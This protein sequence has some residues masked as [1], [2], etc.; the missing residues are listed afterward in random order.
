L[1]GVLSSDGRIAMESI[2]PLRFRPIFQQ[3]LW[4]GRRL[5]EWF[6]D[7]P[8]DGPIAEAWLVSD[9]AKNP[10]VVA[11]GPLAGRS[12]REIG[13]R[14]LGPGHREGERFP[15]LLKFLDAR[16]HLSVQVHPN[17]QQAALV[18]PGERGKTEAWVILRAESGSRIY[19]GLRRGVDERE[20]RQAAAEGRIAGMLHQI[21]PRVGDCIFLPAGTVHAIGA[22]LMLFEVQQTSNITYRLD[23]WN[24]VDPRTGKSRE[25]HLEQGLACIDYS[26][27]PSSR[28]DAVVES[29][30]P[31]RRERLITC[32]YFRLWRNT[33]EMPF[34]VGAKGECRIVVAVDGRGD[35]VAEGRKLPL[36]PGAVW[37]LPADVGEGECRPLERLTVL[38]CGMP[39][40]WAK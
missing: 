27:G 8:S 22:G 32:D 13:S 39:N 28:I 17:D 14:L 19:A 2:P 5:A 40:I 23:D 7:A 33:G 30:L 16:D 9:E 29:L 10:S 4:G 26:R 25:L 15:L 24:R 3:Y 31:A 18:G 21:E 38:E 6:G 35:L 12:L 11:D 37:L 1:N 34:P 20:L 36:R